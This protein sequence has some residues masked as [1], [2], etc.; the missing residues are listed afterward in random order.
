MHNGLIS[1]LLGC[2]LVSI[3]GGENWLFHF[4]HITPNFF[5]CSYDARISFKNLLP[6]LSFLI[7][8]LF[9]IL[10][11]KCYL[12]W[13]IFCPKLSLVT[14]RHAISSVF[15]HVYFKIYYLLSFSSLILLGG[16][17]EINPGLIFSSGQCFSICHLNLNRIT[18]QNY[19]K[20]SFLLLTI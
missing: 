20:L 18:A 1:S 15:L 9:C 16:D 3:S 10:L 7:I 4:N 17:I 6:V 19:A 13:I 11:R 12:I 14:S 8:V 2:R 5:F